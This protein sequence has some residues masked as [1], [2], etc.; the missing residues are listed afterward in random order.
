MA[1]NEGRGKHVFILVLIYNIPNYILGINCS[2]FLLKKITEVLS[3]IIRWLVRKKKS[4]IIFL[5]KYFNLMVQGYLK[6]LLAFYCDRK[7]KVQLSHREILTL[8]FPCLPY[9]EPN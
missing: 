2:L 5:K 4:F 9:L 3:L 6:F 1:E 7:I 8:L